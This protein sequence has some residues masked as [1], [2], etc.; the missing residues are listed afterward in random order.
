MSLI[1][2]CIDSEKVCK[3][4]FLTQ[5]CICSKAELQVFLISPLP[6]GWGNR[7]TNSEIMHINRLFTV[8]SLAITNI[9]QD[10]WRVFTVIQHDFN[11]FIL[12]SGK[13]D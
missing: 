3:L 13:T 11:N 7:A 8:N 10:Y 1:I 2:F 4:L 6:Y 12:N 9:H 5:L